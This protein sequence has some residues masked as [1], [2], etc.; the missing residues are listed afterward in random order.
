MNL[1][2]LLTKE[3]AHIVGMPKVG[4]FGVQI[5][6]ELHIRCQTISNLMKSY[7]L[8]GIVIS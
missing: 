8:Q 3:N 7:Q 4:F 1:Q 5:E 2:S 6:R